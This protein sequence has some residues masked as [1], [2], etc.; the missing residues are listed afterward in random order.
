MEVAVLAEMNHLEIKKSK[1]IFLRNLK[2]DLY[3]LP[4]YLNYRV[5]EMVGSQRRVRLETWMEFKS[6]VLV[7]D[8]RGR[9]D[10]TVRIVVAYVTGVVHDFFVSADV[11]LDEGS[12]RLAEEERILSSGCPVFVKNAVAIMGPFVNEDFAFFLGRK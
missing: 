9:I 8:I 12:A 3:F 6:T 2:F 5:Q 4:F 1:Q 11:G 10:L 7:V